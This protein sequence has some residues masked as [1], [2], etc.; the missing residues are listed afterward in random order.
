MKKV[1]IL[2]KQSNSGSIHDIASD[3]YDREIRFPKGKKFAVVLASYYGD[4][5]TVHATEQAAIQASRRK[6]EYSRQIIGVDGWPYV[7]DKSRSFDGELI[8]DP[9][10]RGPY[11]VLD[12]EEVTQAAAALG[13]VRSEA[14]AESSRANG[15]KGGR[16]RNV[17]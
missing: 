2:Q 17:K 3:L 4:Y 7:V 16:P 8:R 1:I 14:K 15:A 6:N 9:D 11:N 13:S 5:Y 12:F 10:Y